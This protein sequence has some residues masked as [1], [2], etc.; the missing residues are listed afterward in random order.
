VTVTAVIAN[1]TLADIA[2]SYV[3]GNTGSLVITPKADSEGTTTITVTVNN[4]KPKNNLFSRVFSCLCKK[5]N[6]PTLAA[7]ADVTIET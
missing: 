4:G 5:S 7:I 1:P 3:N 2:L 6:F